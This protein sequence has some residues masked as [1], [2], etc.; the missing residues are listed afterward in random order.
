MARDILGISSVVRYLRNPN[1]RVTIKLLRAFGATVGHNTTIKRS[2]L[3]DNAYEDMNSVGDFSYLQIGN[4]CYIGDNSF[5]DLANRILIEDN[6]VIS[7]NASF[8][9]HAECD[10]SSYL[11]VKFP[12]TCAPI[13]VKTGA[14]VGYGA[15]IFPGVTIGCHAVLGAHSLLLDNAEP[16]CLYIGVPARKFRHLEQ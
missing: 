7:A 14:W 6:A 5:F 3:L 9:T 1:P 15:T 8:I 13:V 16:G 2:L 12:R 4:N 11:S 10:R